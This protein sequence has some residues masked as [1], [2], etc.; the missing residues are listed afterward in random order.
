ME[1][2]KSYWYNL[3]GVRRKR[4]WLKDVLLSD[5]SSDEESGQFNEEHL[6]KMLKEHKLKK[7]S[8]SQFYQNEDVSF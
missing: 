1:Q 5:S 3:S 6:L 7:K 4:Q 2:D 8:Q